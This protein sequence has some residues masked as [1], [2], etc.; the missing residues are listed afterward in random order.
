MF[1]LGGTEQGQGT[2]VGEK[3]P[4]YWVWEAAQIWGMPAPL[5]PRISTT[6][7][8]P[9]V[10]P[11]AS[12]SFRINPAIAG[13]TSIRWEFR[14]TIAAPGSTELELR[15]TAGL[16]GAAVSITSYVETRPGVLPGALTF[17]LYWDA[18]AFTPARVTVETMQV[19]VLVCT[20]VGV[21][22]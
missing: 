7:A 17:F 5:P 18:G 11:A 21:C 9:T 4:A 12:A 16:T 2:D 15:F 10:L 20:S 19:T 8:T 3:T 13:N 1:P 6:A 22:P 14:E